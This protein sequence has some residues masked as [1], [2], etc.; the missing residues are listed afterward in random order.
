MTGL[1]YSNPYLS[2]F[3]EFNKFKQHPA[4]QKHIK[5]GMCLQYGA[6]TL[7]EGRL[8]TYGSEK[9]CLDELGS[10]MCMAHVGM[11]VP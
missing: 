6:R 7:N 1:D 10:K 5:G 11:L 4:I 2:P 3:H 9:G 8:C